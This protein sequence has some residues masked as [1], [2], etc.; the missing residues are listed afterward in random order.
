MRLGTAACCLGVSLVVLGAETPRDS[1]ASTEP[2][3]PAGGNRIVLP[4][5][6][7]LT[8]AGLQ[9]ELPGLRPQALAMSP[10]GTMLVTAGKTPEIVVIDPASGNVLRRVPLPSEL[11]TVTAAVS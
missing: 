6:Q 10:D 3:G 11:Q 4:V 8:P 7:V 5:S 2:V 9:V 1:S